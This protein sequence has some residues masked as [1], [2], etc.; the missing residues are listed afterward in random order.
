MKRTLRVLFWLVCFALAVW[1]MTFHPATQGMAIGLATVPVVDGVDDAHAK[2]VL[3]VLAFVS[4]TWLSLWVAEAV[5][6][7]VAVELVRALTKWYYQV[8]WANKEMDEHELAMAG[9][10]S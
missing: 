8:W 2:V 5:A 9:V 1:M 3:G 7:L 6:I 10:V 4:F